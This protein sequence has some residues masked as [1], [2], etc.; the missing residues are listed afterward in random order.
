MSS[1]DDL[2]KLDEDKLFFTDK[3]HVYI[4]KIKKTKLSYNGKKKKNERVLNSKHCCMICGK[5]VLRIR[6][7]LL[8][9]H[10]DHE[11]IRALNKMSQKQQKDALEIMRNKGDHDHN[12]RV[13]QQEKG[14]L[15]LSRR[16]TDGDMKTTDFLPC[17]TCFLYVKDLAKHRSYTKRCKGFD[18][19][20]SSS[21]ASLLAKGL[22]DSG[23]DHIPSEFLKS[24]V[25]SKFINDE[26]S[27]VATKDELILHLGN[28]TIKNVAKNLL[29]RGR[30]AS[31]KMRLAARILIEIRKIMAKEITW[32]EVLKPENFTIIVTAVTTLAGIGKEGN[33]YET[34]SNA[35]KG[36]YVIKDLAN[37][38]E[39]AALMSSPKNLQ[40]AEEAADVIKLMEKNWSSNVSSLATATLDEGRYTTVQSLPVP[41]D[42]RVLSQH[43][44]WKSNS[45]STE[46]I[47][48]TKDGFREGV[49]IA[50]ARLVTFNKRRP[51]EIEA[52]YLDDYQKRRKEGEPHMSQFMSSLSDLEKYLLTA[53]ELITVRG[54]R[55]RGV[56]V[57]LPP[58]L[59][60][61]L[62]LLASEEVRKAVQ[63]DNSPY[64]FPNFGDGVVRAV[65]SLSKV[66][67]SL[68][69]KLQ[70][71]SSIKA[72]RLRKYLATTLQV[73]SLEAYELEWVA[74]HLGHTMH[75]HKDYYRMMSTTIEKTKMA[76]LM[77]LSESGNLDQYRGKSLDKISCEDVVIPESALDDDVDDEVQSPSQPQTT[78]FQSSEQSASK[79]S[80]HSDLDKKRIKYTERKEDSNW[81]I[82]P[83]YQK[84]FKTIIAEK[85]VPGNS[86]ITQMTT[87]TALEIVP[88]YKIR[89]KINADVQ[90]IK[91]QQT[92]KN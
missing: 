27:C 62:E 20:M 55:G 56:P 88:A 29:K 24:E 10:E 21:R 61:L 77:V 8:H 92:S 51:G 74:S 39:S 58:D 32:D 16:F 31:D 13:L 89:N 64:L 49:E 65:E 5:L 84:I 91:R 81:K 60:D 2:L 54:K 41:E 85:K 22:L 76:K 33:T 42:L 35:L 18:G 71:P 78:A 40:R 46:A 67:D 48:K 26:I 12:E 25:L 68:K 6:D 79:R 14:E 72:T 3:R 73:F 37:I 63:V 30:Y 19:D 43:V 1:P 57:L 47:L 53:H 59:Y 90:K 86:T 15:L 80:L 45:L 11:E 36:G 69:R 34:P 38:K 44:Q 87:G 66:V 52:I 83:D 17:P 23:T 4:K 50:Q 9:V 70:D 82:H 28:Q 75:V 7:H